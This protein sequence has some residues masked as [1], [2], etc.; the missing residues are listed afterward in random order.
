MVKYYKDIFDEVSKELGLSYKEVEEA[1]KSYY[2][3]IV[4]TIKELDFNG[5]NV[6]NKD[7]F[8][9]LQT[10]FN[11]PSIGKLY[12]SYDKYAGLK[13]MNKYY[14]EHIENGRVQE[15]ND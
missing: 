3:F 6:M 12:A 7:E 11:I 1:Y 2:H 8:N 13:R 9:E 10:S 4:K 15:E 14:I 5:K